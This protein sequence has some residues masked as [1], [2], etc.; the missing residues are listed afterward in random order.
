MVL[1]FTATIGC[2]EERQEVA[3]GRATPDDVV[4]TEPPPEGAYDFIVVGSG[5]GGGPVA[6]RLA[7]AGCH[8][9]LL[10]A[11]EDVGTRRS[12]RVPAKHAL[13][14]EEAGMAW[15]FFVDHHADA[16][17]DEQDSKY[18]EEGILYPRGSALGGS[19]AVNALVTVLP[20]PSDWNRLATITGDEGWRA[21]KMDAYYDRVQEWLSI[22]LPD[23]SL[24]MGDP[25]IVRY[26]IAAANTYAEE[27]AIGSSIDPNDS[28]QTASELGRLLQQDLNA[29]LRHTETTGM[30]RLPLA[31]KDGE[32]NGTRELIVDTVKEGY[33]LTVK[34]GAFVTRVLF[35]T[36]SGEPRANGVEWVAGKDVYR[37]S[38]EPGLPG[39]ATIE[40]ATREVILSA[41]AFNS[42]QLLML[43]GIGD[44]RHLEEVGVQPLVDRPGVGLN[45][46]DRYEV[47]VVTELD[48]PLSVV[49]PCKLTGEWGTDPCAEQWEMGSGVYE[50][51]GFLASFLRRS[52][53]DVALADLQVFAT[54]SDARGYYPGY[55]ADAVEDPRR[56]SWLILKGHTQNN[57]GYV[58]LRSN[59]PLERPTIQFSYYDEND[60]LG[61]PDLQAV[62]NG[63]KFVRSIEDRMRDQ[64]VDEHLE[65]VWPGAEVADDTAIAEWI[66]NESWGHHASCSNRM[67]RANDPFAVVDGRFRVIGTDSLRVV[68]ASVWPEIPGTFIALPT[69]MLAERAADLILEDQR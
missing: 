54:P 39:D 30:F 14:T 65:E 59:D 46:Q 48:A 22:E 35:D 47:A 69:F 33:P 42:P 66:R 4:C 34:T 1:A 51:S 18:T 58:R 26:L 64:L 67:G 17:I 13:S 53:E 27:S 29:S 11:G 7:R 21:S 6:S 37:A 25:S 10:E 23:P 60:P 63:V 24:A 45:L 44:A 61:D 2:G 43:S 50:T 32:R 41:G 56:L 52:S 57:D 5:A 62:V 68:D 9:L 31:T 19:T 40:G 20:S 16:T 49:E 36:T 3:T 15:W 8:V 12:Y 38:L 28:A 55:A